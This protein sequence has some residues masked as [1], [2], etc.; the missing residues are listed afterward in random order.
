MAA[1]N[2]SSMECLC[3]AVFMLIA[4]LCPAETLKEMIRREGVPAELCQTADLDKQ[5][6]SGTDA[7][8]EDSKIIATYVQTAGST[9]L[10][11]SFYLFRLDKP[12]GRWSGTKLH[13]P[14][15]ETA[16]TDGRVKS[17]QGGSFGQIVTSGDFI[18]LDGHVSPSAS[19]TMVTTRDLTVRGTFYGW[20]VG[21]FQAG[22]VVYEHSQVHFAPTHYV[23]LSIYDPAHR[24]SLKIYPLKPY[25]RVRLAY[26]SAV[27]AAYDKCCPRVLPDKTVAPPLQDCGGQF[28]NHHCDAELFDNSL[29][30]KLETN[31]VTDSLA[32]STTF[33]DAT[34]KHPVVVYVYRNISDPTKMQFR[35]FLQDELVRAYGNLALSGYLSPS[36]LS[37]LFAGKR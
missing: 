31:T 30:D 26:I 28:G 36:M 16:A 27:R 17:C 13:W 22:R 3:I 25:Q 23:E 32:F 8:A 2:R 19:C 20:I 10:D 35:E 29:R 6:T 33:G 18:Y 21:Q 24:T 15:F 5:T 12:N 11:N 37:T 14:E 34:E 1:K 4:P 9:T 7:D